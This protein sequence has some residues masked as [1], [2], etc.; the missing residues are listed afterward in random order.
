MV[1]RE[2]WFHCGYKKQNRLSRERKAASVGLFKTIL[3]YLIRLYHL[4]RVR[5]I[6]SSMPGESIL[7]NFAKNLGRFIVI[8]GV[9]GSGK[10]EQFKLLTA[11]LEK[12]GDKV[13]RFDFPQYGK[14]SAYLVEEYLNGKLGTAEEV[15]PY[16]ASLF[17][18]LDR[19]QASFEL[20]KK[21]AEGSM[22]VSNRYVG[23]NFAH[24]GGKFNDKGER[25]KYF[26]WNYNLEYI[27]LGIPKPDVSIILH[28]PAAMAQ[29][30]VDKKGAREYLSGSKCDIHEADLRHL[31]NAEEAYLEMA[32][33]F[34]K[35]FFFIECVE[36]GKLLTIE[37]IHAKVWEAVKEKIEI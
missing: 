31:Q 25:R 20:R 29:Q 33:L 32:S 9:D 14:P 28:V 12:G 24:Q 1:S 15:G 4:E 34:P 18:A 21:L 5:V 16:R 23:S 3:K 10:T 35:D 13:T 7:Q 26:E 37:A 19:Y 22:V 2:G 8:E 27:I 6:I 30:L 36:E 17:Y 11:R